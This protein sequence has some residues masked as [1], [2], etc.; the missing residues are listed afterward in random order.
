[1]K[2]L[3]KEQRDDQATLHTIKKFLIEAGNST[4]R[5]WKTL[6]LAQASFFE[7]ANEV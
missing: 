1:M 4:S 6:T 3:L 7:G 2:V 5:N